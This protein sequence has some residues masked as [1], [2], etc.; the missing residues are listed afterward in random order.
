MT[1]MVG[2]SG[3]RGIVGE[4]LTGREVR[5]LGQALRETFSPLRRIVV[6][7]DSRPSGETLLCA[8]AAALAEPGRTIIDL[9]VVTTPAAGLMT[10]QLKADLGLLMTASHNPAPYN[11]IKLLTAEGHAPPKKLVEPIYHRFRELLEN[12]PENDQNADVCDSSAITGLVRNDEAG[13]RHVERVL[14]LFD[15]K[16]IRQGR[17]KVVLDSVHGAGGPSGRMLLDALGAEI[18]HLYAEP[19]GLFP[20]RPEPVRDNLSDLCAAVKRAGAAVGFAQDP[21]ADRLAI[22]DEH[23]WYIGEEYTQAL[24]V[25]NILRSHPGAVATNLSS[26]KLM[27]D[28][29]S[30]FPRSRLYRSPVG[31]ANV[32]DLMKEVRAVAGGEGNGGLIDPR[33]GLIRDSLAAMAHVLDLMTARGE[34]LSAIVASLP[35]YSTVKTQLPCPPAR[36]PEVLAAARSLFQEGRVDERDGLRVDLPHGWFQ[37]RGSNTEPILRI[38]AE[39][40]EERLA[41]EWVERLQTQTA[42]ML[43]SAEP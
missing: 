8:L 34:P 32:V 41:L 42:A 24:G 37:I 10:R 40:R 9:G 13:E 2:V 7:R 16:A 30:L 43:E 25:M 6:G 29:T 17:W 3:I 15:V 26:S 31:E 4:T 39:A 23:G 1:L 35:R 12:A 5:L 27:D 28:V 20:H 38:M 22:V 18:N 11:G 19:S 36:V 33:V 14:G 21:D